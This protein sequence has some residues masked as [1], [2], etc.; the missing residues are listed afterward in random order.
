[1]HLNDQDLA[2][3]LDPAHGGGPQRTRHHVDQCAACQDAVG[4]VRA[5][6][7]RIGTLLYLLD[8][9]ARPVAFAAIE[10]RAIRRNAERPGNVRPVPAASDRA[11][12]DAGSSREV[13]ARRAYRARAPW[14]FV[15]LACVAA[16][17][18]AAVPRS[19]LRQFFGSWVARHAPATAVRSVP[20][21]ASETRQ[22]GGP[23]APRGLAIVPRTGHVVLI[24]QVPQPASVVEVRTAVEGSSKM[25]SVSLLASGNGATYTV[26]HDTILVDNRSAPRVTFEVDLPP[27]SKREA[28]TLLVGDRV[29]FRRRGGTLETRAPKSNDGSYS[30]PLAAGHGP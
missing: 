11:P 15:A 24:W 8:H 9:P 10:A 20:G 27:P 16:A 14:G 18:A 4:R 29:V 26:S 30:I 2:A 13:K 7:D 19:P 6:Q 5:S 22:S 17:A 21:G 28:I 23:A 3:Y 1:M 25:G 12:Y